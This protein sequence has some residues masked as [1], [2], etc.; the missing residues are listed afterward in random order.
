MLFTDPDETVLREEIRELKRTRKAVILAHLYQRPSVHYVA[1]FT[2]DS[3]ELSRRAVEAKADVIVFCGV[4]FMAETASI[5]NSDKIVLL[6]EP[7][8]GCDMA[9]MATAEQVRR[10]RAELPEDTAVVSYVN[11]TAEVKAESDICCT[12]ANAVKVVQSLSQEHVLFVP[13]RNLGSYVAEQTDKD[14]IL[15][16]GHCYVHDPNISAD[17]IRELKRRHPNAAVMIHPECNAAVRRLGDFIGST[18]QMLDYAS[19][20]SKRAF[21]V[22]TEESMLHPL[23]EQNPHKMF[24]SSGS[25]CSSMRVTTLGSVRCALDRMVNVVSVP[26]DIRERAAGAVSAMMAV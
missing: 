8:A 6:P 9:A 12:S 16:D 1:D 3:L 19:R 24:L 17:A 22:G 5:L 25:V 18:S 26:A 14:V 21:I 7:S 2:G 11:S 23:Q 15:W 4:R 10:K 13:D 20:S